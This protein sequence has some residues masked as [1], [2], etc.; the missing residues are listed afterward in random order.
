[1]KKIA[2]LTLAGI[3]GS[4]SQ[5]AIAQQ[6]FITASDGIRPAYV[7][8]HSETGMRPVSQPTLST[9]RTT[10]LASRLIASARRF[11]DGTDFVLTD[12][13]LYVFSGGRGGDL[14]SDFIKY[15]KLSTYDLSSGSLQ[16]KLH[17]AQT[18][19][20]AGNLT[21]EKGQYWNVSSASFVNTYLFS[22]T[23][24]AFGK[25]A[26]RL[27]QLWNGSAWENVSNSI[28]SYTPTKNLSEGLLQKWDG[29]TWINS[30]YEIYTYT[31]SDKVGTHTYKTWN[32][33][34][35]RWDTSAY[36]VNIYDASGNLV[37]ESGLSRNVAT[38]ILQNS[39][40]TTYAYDAAGH[41]TSKTILNWDSF[42][43]SWK[44]GPAW[45]FEYNDK[46]NQTES[47][48]LSGGGRDTA[49][50]MLYT[51]NSYDQLLTEA[52][53][54]W[55]KT[56]QSWI[57]T[58]EGA[59][60]LSNYYY[61]EYTNSV[62]E[63]IPAAAVLLYPVPAQNV[64]QLAVQ[65]SSTESF[66]LSLTDLQ[67]RVVQTRV[68]AATAQLNETINVSALPAGNYLLQLKGD[69][70]ASLVRQVTVAH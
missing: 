10:A 49:E 43:S 50:H 2:T 29:S 64:L 58:K 51:Y 36:I 52:R 41:Q 14:N 46:G 5:Q 18:F 4:L 69:R 19:D 8:K 25:E 6:S 17:T 56:T 66:T 68:I 33:A 13:S 24:T 59:D 11:H 32:N 44:N 47:I 57:V 21:E 7:T 61:E 28:S 40:R 48:L 12:S 62:K 26:T 67:G 1:M 3:I 54:H 31:A 9:A 39:Y 37:L 38:G 34:L 15:D 27:M 65:L 70:G 16:H 60:Y 30:L 55:D 22:Y 35:A 45:V 53:E 63:T 23:S 42:S 20:A